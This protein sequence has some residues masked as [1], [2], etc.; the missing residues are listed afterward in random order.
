MNIKLNVFG[1]KTGKLTLTCKIDLSK[2]E[3]EL[4]KKYDCV[5]SNAHDVEKIM[6]N[7]QH[8]LAKDEI[9]LIKKYPNESTLK[10]YAKLIHNRIKEQY[11]ICKSAFIDTSYDLTG[12]NPYINAIEVIPLDDLYAFRLD[13]GRPAAISV[14]DLNKLVTED[15]S[16]IKENQDKDSFN[17]LHPIGNM[18]FK[19]DDG[20]THHITPVKDGLIV[21]GDE[22]KRFK[23]NAKGEYFIE[24]KPLKI[25]N[26]DGYITAG[27]KSE[28]GNADNKIIPSVKEEEYKPMSRK[29]VMASVIKQESF[30]SP[31]NKQGDVQPIA[32]K[33]KMGRPFT[34]NKPS[35]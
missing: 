5:I 28:D 10:T 26:M 6:V 22:S 24:N 12:F 11:Y 7:Y 23:I 27:V 4:Y 8:V 3:E 14:K 16:T 34:K 33:K 1:R 30:I 19:G 25:E 35:V 18:M 31:N 21:D 15:C 32:P 17:M 2:E 29:A 9:E 20:I 13:D